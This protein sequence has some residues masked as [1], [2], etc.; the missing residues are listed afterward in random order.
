[1]TDKVNSKASQTRIAQG[2][3]RTIEPSFP[4]SVQGLLFFN[5]VIAEK[6]K[7]DWTDHEITLAA[8]LAR[9][10]DDVAA[11]AETEGLTAKLNAIVSLRR[12]M[13]IHSPAKA[14]A[15]ELQR[16][17]EIGKEIENGYLETA[18]DDL[19]ARPH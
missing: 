4:L 11:D 13:G 18:E 16:R 19:I 9:T 6:P 14:P 8:I 3:N 12:S 5:E 2:A 10:M 17:R 7:A 1:M 15:R